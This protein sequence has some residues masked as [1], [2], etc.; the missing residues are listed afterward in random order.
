MKDINWDRA[1]TIY[2][3]LEKGISD[4]RKPI[5]RRLSDL[6]GIFYDTESLE[7]ML[8]DNNPLIYEFF[9]LGPPENPGDLA[10]GTSIVYP[11]KVGNE[12]F[13][14]KGHF[15]SILETAEIYYCLSGKGYMLMENPEGDWDAKE[16]TPGKSCLCA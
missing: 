2:F 9:D 4:E 15:H 7:L 3:D 8:K 11:G 6:K 1:F 13:M 5:Q 16:M 10:F 12:Y 14:T